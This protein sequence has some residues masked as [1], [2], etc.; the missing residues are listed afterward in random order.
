MDNNMK[1]TIIKLLNDEHNA[2]TDLAS[3]YQKKEIIREKTKEM[4][5]AADTEIN[6]QLYTYT[7]IHNQLK[8]V[9]R[10]I[11]DTDENQ[12]TE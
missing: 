5:K 12:I 6:K 9:I 11:S 1:D 2:V 4:L 3:A 7:K 10:D 8:E